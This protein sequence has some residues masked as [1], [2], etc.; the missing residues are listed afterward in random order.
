MKATLYLAALAAVLAGC[1]ASPPDRFVDVQKSLADRGQ[2]DV[3][4]VGHDTTQ[5][6]IDRA[7]AGALA[8][9]LSVDD[10]V[11][12]AL[13]NNHD[14]QA[15]LDE[16]GI[17]RASVLQAGLLPN[18]VLSVIPRFPDRPPS[19]VD[20]ELSV[21]TDFITLLSLPAHRKLAAFQYQ[22]AVQSS[23]N[24]V[25]DLA[26]RTRIAFYRWQA[27]QQLL[28]LRNA[29][30]QASDAGAE[31]A[32]KLH[33]AGNISDLD[34]VSQQAVDQQSKIDLADAQAELLDQREMLGSLMSVSDAQLEWKAQG[35]LADPP[36]DDVLPKDLEAAALNQRLD[37]ASAAS[38]VQA[39]AQILGIAK[40][41]RFL[42]QGTIGVDTEKTPDGQR[43]TGPTLS[44]PIPLM[45][46][47]QAG[48]MRN[49]ARFE[50]ASQHYTALAMQIR[51]DV[52]RLRARME[53]A[54]ARAGMIRTTLLPLEQ[55]VVDESL[56]FYNGMLLGTFQLLTVRQNQINVQQQYIQS[57]RD[58]WI[59]RAEL[60]QAAGGTFVERKKP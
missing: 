45:D 57:L 47:G 55:Q 27:A 7:V 59:A 34:L 26:A 15:D 33:D 41:L 19:G 36:T 1:S 23:A 30:T 51:S 3:H 21:E 11:R 25:L 18:P 12:I 20:L 48:I 42:Q 8:K 16:L 6:Q 56:R 5:Q 53:S 31:L 39:D 29:V 60:L 14:L 37:L 52:R 38:E 24:T 32:Q 28:E 17:A 49:K 10:A 50:Q 13:L 44:I 35:N 54:R 58:Y 22:Q 4:W 9:P 43:V 46:T 2:P 40:D